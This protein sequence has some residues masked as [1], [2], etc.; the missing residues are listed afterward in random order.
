MKMKKARLI[1]NPTSRPGWIRQHLP[2]V[3]KILRE[4]GVDVEIRTSE[5]PGD[6]ARLARQCREGF[7]AVIVAGGDGSI[8]EALG[9]LVQSSTPLGI[10]PLGTVNVFAREVGIPLD[11]REAARAI[12]DNPARAFDLGWFGSHPF[13][14]MVSYGYDAWVVRQNPLSL[15]RWFGRYSYVLTALFKMPWYRNRPIV[16]DMGDGSAPRTA[17]FALFANAARYA[18]D[19]RL[20]PRADMH[21]G[22]LD[23]VLFHSPGPLGPLKT[24]WA[25]ITGTYLQKSWVWTGRTDKLRFSTEAPDCFQVDGDALEPD[26]DEIRVERDAVKILAP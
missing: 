2:E 1:I 13:L 25:I 10:I 3:E 24:L 14:L 15:K 23:V 9:A 21:D 11:P 8:N 17:H 20:A 7:D 19:H 4:G 5:A 22:L 26:S 12:L 6:P 18:G 16:V